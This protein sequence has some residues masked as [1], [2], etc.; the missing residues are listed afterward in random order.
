MKR[1]TVAPFWRAALLLFTISTA[2]LLSLTT[3]K[4]DK[5]VPGVFGIDNRK[6]VESTDPPFGSIGRIN[7]AGFKRKSHCTGT[8]IAPDIVVTAAHCVINARN[9]AVHAT[10][11]V[12]FVSGFRRGEYIGASTARR[13]ILPVN[14]SFKLEKG[15]EALLQDIAVILL[16]KEI[17]AASVARTE[18][19]RPTG[20]PLSHVSYPRDRPYLP[21]IDD[22]CKLLGE[23]SGLWFTNCDTNFGGSGGPL[24]VRS[25]EDFKI[26]AVMSAIVPG[27]FSIAVP[28][29]HFAP[30]LERAAV[31]N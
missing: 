11:S 18:S 14:Y 30:L 10:R 3:A 15:N 9:K 2:A 31:G 25:G 1:S 13:I 26:A 12:H 29:R 22:Q 19:A 5:N 23:K 28:I 17:D 24:M 7:V 16:E 6:V 4:A 20:A 21:V 8:L 27:R